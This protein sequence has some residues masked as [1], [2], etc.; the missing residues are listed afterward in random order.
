VG[1]I[2]FINVNVYGSFQL[3]TVAYLACMELF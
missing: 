3:S 1:I 2:S